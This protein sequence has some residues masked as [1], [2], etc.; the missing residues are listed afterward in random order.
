ML[1]V[2]DLEASVPRAE[3]ELLLVARSVGDVGLA[4]DAQVGAVGVED[5]HGVEECGAS[6]LEEAD[7]QHHAKLRG[8]A[9]KVLQQG[10]GR[11]ILS[12]RE[13]A[14]VLLLRKVR[15]SEELL[16]KD[17]LRALLS[18]RAH[19]STGA[20]HVLDLVVRHAH[21]RHGQGHISRS[22]AASSPL[23]RLHRRRHLQRRARA[24]RFHAR[25]Q[26]APPQPHACPREQRGGKSGANH[27][28]ESHDAAGL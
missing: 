16:Q 10:A 12:A 19:Q 23:R 11:C 21:L 2:E 6:S 27:A 14:P 15:T 8:Q 28:R 9:R 1:G 24:V 4:I 17:D 25:D 5:R 26:L 7:G 22:R 3:V 20:G 18:R 13:V